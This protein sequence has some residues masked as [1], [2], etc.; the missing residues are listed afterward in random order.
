MTIKFLK[1]NKPLILLV[2]ALFLIVSFVVFVT[3][4][5][6]YD[7]E[8]TLEEKSEK[9]RLETAKEVI[10]VFF[11]G[12][13]RQLLFFKDIAV[14][15]AYVEGGFTSSLKKD[16]VLAA[17]HDLTSNY[18]DL[19][20]ISIIDTGN[21]EIV[22]V[23][24]NYDGSHLVDVGGG[25][26]NIMPVNYVRYPSD[27]KEGAI[28]VSSVNLYSEQIGGGVAYIP[29]IDLATPLFDSKGTRKGFL[30]MNIF[31]S[32]VFSQLPANVFLNTEDGNIISFRSDGT[33]ELNKS[34]FKLIGRLG[35][36]DI[37]KKESIHYL[38]ADILSM[39]KLLLGNKQDLSVFKASMLGLAMPPASLV[40]LFISLIS[41]V[42]YLNI[43]RYKELVLS[44]KTLIHS[45]A[46]LTEYRDSDTGFH[47]KR[48]KQYALALTRQLQN[49]NKYRDVITE[50]FIQDIADASMLHDIGKVGI[51][52]AILLKPGKLTSEEYEQMKKHIY[53]GK[54]VLDKDLDEFKTKQS[55]L[56]IGRNICAYHH[57][58]YDGTGYV[59][60]KGEDIPLEA[61]IFAL[62]DA[63]DA[64]RASRPYEGEVAH[65]KVVNRIMTDRGRHF[66]PDIVDAFMKCS[67]E[68][69][70][71]SNSC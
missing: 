70:E 53:I 34:E 35:K 48:T 27:L 32:K 12:L 36:L 23:Q 16:A 49:N 68:F 56:I 43:S 50:E 66:D 9:A 5:Q 59:G 42:A 44:Q 8:M 55:F 51:K 30:V 6:I 18:P 1:Q 24:N 67:T 19:Y 21:N 33:L 28:Y 64:I 47:L 52:D 15:R 26:H 62:C 58:K 71:I 10:E 60:L 41:L 39:R 31:L 40:I 69:F 63:Y 7:L 38:T 57:E 3:A 61:R 46:D 65:E 2:L 37:S 13:S 4:K 25:T 54:N 45:L 22:K 29:S 20:R 14:T 11:S 17:F